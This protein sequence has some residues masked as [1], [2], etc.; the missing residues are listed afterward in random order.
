MYYNVSLM[1]YCIA[2]YFAVLLMYSGCVRIVSRVYWGRGGGDLAA[3][4]IR[5]YLPCIAL[6]R[7]GVSECISG[8]MYLRCITSVLWCI[9]C[10]AVYRRPRS[11]PSI[12]PLGR[13]S[14]LRG[15]WRVEMRGGLGAE[16]DSLLK[17]V[18]VCAAP[19][20]PNTDDT[21]RIQHQYSPIPICN[22]PPP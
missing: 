12:H 16:P 10:L 7:C 22:T 20:Q 1:Y 13:C 2:V 5:L 17:L 4:L 14:A 19:I 6:Y 18:R 21:A 11:P 3:T 9:R 8:I 15:G